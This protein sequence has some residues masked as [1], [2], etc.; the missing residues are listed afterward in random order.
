MGVDFEPNRID[1]EYSKKIAEVLD[2]NFRIINVDIDAITSDELDE[3][4]F[5]QPNTSHL[6]LLFY[7]VRDFYQRKIWIVLLLVVNRLIVF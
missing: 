7:P 6:S 1:I 5:I 3:L 2:L 4:I